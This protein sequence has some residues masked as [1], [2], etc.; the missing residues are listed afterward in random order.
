MPG[1]VNKGAF[2]SEGS[3]ST[4]WVGASVVLSDVVALC[5]LCIAAVA[6]RVPPL[7][8]L[9]ALVTGKGITGADARILQGKV[10]RWVGE[11]VG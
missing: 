11:I 6:R 4:V 8:V 7:W 5:Y 2:R 3:A 9:K 1:L 10:S